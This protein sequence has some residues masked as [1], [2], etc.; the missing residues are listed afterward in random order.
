M[1]KMRQKTKA[2][3]IR[4]KYL[5]LRREYDHY[6]IDFIEQYNIE[7]SNNAREIRERISLELDKLRDAYINSLGIPREFI[8][9]IEDDYFSLHVNHHDLSISVSTTEN[10]GIFLEDN[11]SLDILRQDIKT[12]EHNLERGKRILEF[13]TDFLEEL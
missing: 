7:N 11:I 12:A 10:F 5:N 9:E 3:E 1:I 2:E 13:V 8:T 6:Y 4:K